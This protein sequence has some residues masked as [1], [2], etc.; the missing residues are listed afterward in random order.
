MSLCG[1]SLDRIWTEIIFLI[2]WHTL[3]EQLGDVSASPMWRCHITKY[4]AQI[5]ADRLRWIHHP[6]IYNHIHI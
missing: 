4:L 5:I 1:T 6:H 2:L 3:C